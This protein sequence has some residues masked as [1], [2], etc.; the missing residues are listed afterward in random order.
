MRM[1]LLIL[2]DYI[3]MRQQNSNHK[4]K[5]YRNNYIILIE[6]KHYAIISLSPRINTLYWI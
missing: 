4:I 5:K 2:N 3:N 1:E 6:D